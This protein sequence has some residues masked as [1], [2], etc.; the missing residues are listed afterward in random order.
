MFDTFF[1]REDVR[2]YARPSDGLRE[3]TWIQAGREFDPGLAIPGSM[4]ERNHERPHGGESIRHD[5][6]DRAQIQRTGLLEPL[7]AQKKVTKGAQIGIR[8]KKLVC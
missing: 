1:L 2:D 4:D 7:S 5:R 3:Q 6:N 8:A